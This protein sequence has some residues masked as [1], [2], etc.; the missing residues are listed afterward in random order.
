M[1]AEYTFNY[2]IND[3]HLHLG[4]SSSGTTHNLDDLIRYMDKFDIERA[5]L[6]T[7]NHVLTRPLN[8]R[9]AECTAKYPDRLIGYGVINPREENAVDEVRRCLTELGMKGIK[10]HSW[11]HGYYPENLSNLDPVIDAIEE[12]QVPILTHTGASLLSLP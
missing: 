10:M 1:Y 12:Y 8:D 4:T 11:K 3:F 5:G 6:S 2:K 7:I 9:I